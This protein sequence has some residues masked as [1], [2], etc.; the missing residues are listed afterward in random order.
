[1][2][3]TATPT[4]S[5]YLVWNL[6]TG[7]VRYCSQYDTAAVPETCTTEIGTGQIP[8]IPQG[9]LTTGVFNFANVNILPAA[10]P[11]ALDIYLVGNVHNLPL[12]I[13]AQNTI[14]LGTSTTHD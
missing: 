9:G 14:L 12:T 11:G 5:R 6:S 7:L 3:S 8:G 4:G 13:L 10:S 2:R 1:F